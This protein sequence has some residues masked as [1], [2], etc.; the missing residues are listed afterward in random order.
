MTSCVASHVPAWTSAAE[1]RQ[2]WLPCVPIA[3]PSVLMRA[4]ARR[5]MPARPV[6]WQLG[7]SRLLV[8]RFGLRGA[9]YGVDFVR[10]M[11]RWYCLV[12]RRCQLHV[13]SCSAD[14]K[15]L[16]CSRVSSCAAG[17]FSAAG[18]GSCTPCS[19]GEAST[20]PGTQ[21]KWCAVSVAR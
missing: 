13:S 7:P 6:H 20:Q 8:L 17:K 18:A 5:P 15:A 12:E 1:R 19:I 21:N 9:A 10:T 14:S 16:N 3:A 4:R 11:R 2:D